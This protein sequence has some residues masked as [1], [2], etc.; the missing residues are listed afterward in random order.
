MI[1]WLAFKLNNS[2]GSIRILHKHFAIMNVILSDGGN[3]GYESYKRFLTIIDILKSPYKWLKIQMNA[4]P[5]LGAIVLVSDSK[6]ANIWHMHPTIRCAPCI[7]FHMQGPHIGFVF[8]WISKVYAFVREQRMHEKSVNKGVTPLSNWRKSYC[9][10]PIKELLFLSVD[11][12]S[13]SQSTNGCLLWC[14]SM[15]IITSFLTFFDISITN[16]LCHW[17]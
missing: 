8:M 10:Y 3:Y 2:I 14:A 16:T 17:D 13:Y 4:F 12:V 15:N 5:L 7:T 6:P 11:Q 1:I 9:M